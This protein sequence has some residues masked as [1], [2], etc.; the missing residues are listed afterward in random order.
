MTRHSLSLLLAVAGAA[1]AQQ[2]QPPFASSPVAAKSS[3]EWGNIIGVRAISGGRLLVNDITGRKVVLLDS[4]L[5]AVAVVADTTPATSTAYSGRIAGL[6]PY[7]GDSTLFVDPQSMSMMVV[8]PNGKIGRVM[9]LPRSEDAMMLGGPLSAQ[10]ALDAN[11]RLVYRSPFRF[12]RNGTPPT[13]G[14][15]PPFRVRRTL[16]RSS[17]SI[18]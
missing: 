6:I 9:A 10:S 16:P 17:A 8:D 13:P 12:V 14:S 3:V 5:A 4:A 15:A 7:H 18:S 1:N 11:G 2:Q